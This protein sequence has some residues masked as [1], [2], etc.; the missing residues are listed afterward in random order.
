MKTLIAASALTL[1]ANLAF[2][3][4]YQHGNFA[5]SDLTPGYSDLADGDLR[6]VVRG[7]VRVSL[8]DYYADN[9]E[10]FYEHAPDPGAFTVRIGGPG[11]LDAWYAGNPDVIGGYVHDQ[12]VLISKHEAII[13]QG[14]TGDGGV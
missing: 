4:D 10:V 8:R 6:P 3:Q 7:K 11:S 5:S 13:R 2:A 9:P 14:A 12:G 1:F